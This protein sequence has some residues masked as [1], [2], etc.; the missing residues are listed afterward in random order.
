MDINNSLNKVLKSIE[1]I[2]F[3]KDTK[4]MQWELNIGHIVYLLSVYIIGIHIVLVS[5][6]QRDS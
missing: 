2:Q 1:C 5:V 4:L 3:A 6:S